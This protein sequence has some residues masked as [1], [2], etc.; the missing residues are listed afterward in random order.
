MKP[1]LTVY[2]EYKTNLEIGRNILSKKGTFSVSQT[3]QK[4]KQVVMLFCKCL[5]GIVPE[6]LFNEMQKY[7]A[8]T[9]EDQLASSRNDFLREL[10][11]FL[12][13]YCKCTVSR[14]SL[15]PLHNI[16]KPEVEV[17]SKMDYLQVMLNSVHSVPE[18]WI[19]DYSEFYMSVDLYYGTQVLDGHSNKIPKTVKLDQFFPRIPLDLYAR[20]TRLNLCRYPRETR[21]VVS[22]SG[23]LRNGGQLQNNSTN[24]PNHDTVMLGYCSVPLYDENLWVSVCF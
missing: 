6:K 11:S 15:P 1:K 2:Y 23:T 7:L 21:I 9:T 20:F 4:V 22:I 18:S 5:H 14:Y 3:S 16:K 12:E 17:L 24:D 10:H 8:A 19:R 13:L